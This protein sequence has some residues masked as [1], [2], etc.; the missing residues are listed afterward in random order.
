MAD[1]TSD[2]VKSAGLRRELLIRGSG[3]HEFAKVPKP[4]KGY[5]Q[6][7][8]CGRGEKDGLKG[9]WQFADVWICGD[10]ARQ[11]VGEGQ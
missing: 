2:R 9:L 8:F 10:H 3:Y 4:W 11:I 6:C 7:Y 5:K 1:A